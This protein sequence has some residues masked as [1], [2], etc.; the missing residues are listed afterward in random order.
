MRIRV[1]PILMA[2][3]VTAT[4]MALSAGHAAA[5][6]PTSVLIVNPMTGETGALYA[7]DRHY[8]VLQDA[9]APAP[10]IS[11]ERPAQLSGGPGT[12][13]INITWLIHDVSVWRVDRVRLEFKYVWVQT[14][15]LTDGTMP[16]NGTDAWHVASDSQAVL[17]VLDDLG[18]LPGQ[19]SADADKDGSLDGT[20]QLGADESAAADERPVVATPAPSLPG[21]QWIAAAAASGIALGA[22]G[23]PALAAVLR[24]RPSGLRQ[25]FVDI[26]PPDDAQQ[27]SGQPDAD[28]AKAPSLVLDLGDLNPADL[29][30]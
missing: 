4:T 21:W 24:R 16:L 25:Q 15:E 11:V 27:D 3:A 22:M 1:R 8:Q 26:D 2:L 20:G 5:G 19:D 30:R 14:S 10:N 13:A 12:P 6:G 17:E 9:L 28:P 7:S 29:P 23:R 18:V